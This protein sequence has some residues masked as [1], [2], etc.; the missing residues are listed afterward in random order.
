MNEKEKIDSAI[1]FEGITSIKA[2]ISGCENGINN[3]KIE[4]VYFDVQKTRSKYR[5]LGYLK[6]KQKTHDFDIEFIDSDRLDSMC[7]GQTH[8]GIIAKCGQR[9]FSS[10]LPDTP[11]C[12]FSVML[13]GI[14]DPFNFG[15]A[16]RSLYAF[17]AKEIIL[18]TRNWMSVAPI[19][20]RS[21]AGTSEMISMRF[22]DCEEIVSHYKSIGYTVVSAAKENSVDLESASFRSPILLII[23]GE[24]RGISRKIL[25][26]SDMIVRIEYG[27]GFMSSLSAASASAILGY[28]ISKKI[29]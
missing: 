3:R 24:K 10:S 15:Y 20:C 9:D 28:E 22:G 16:V 26:I 14:E 21:S 5:E 19:V 17:G 25:D 11:V 13:E 7:V 18:P 27:T 23:G 12:D 4:T 6:N 2:I 29:R 8:G 1:Y